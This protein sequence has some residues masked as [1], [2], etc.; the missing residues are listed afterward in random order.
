[1]KAVFSYILAALSMAIFSAAARADWQQDAAASQ[2]KIPDAY[3]HV[4]VD[5]HLNA[6][7]PMDL[8]FYDQKAQK[9]RF[10]DYFN[11]GRPV[12]LQ[13][14]YLECPM[15][16]DQVSRG[17]IES[18]KK[19]S[20][21]LGKDFDFIFVS[22]DPTDSPAAAAIKLDSYAAAYGRP[23]SASG[24]HF[25][26]GTESQIQQLAVAVGFR[27]QPANNGQFAHPAV[28]MIVSPEGKITRY[29]YG[30]NFPS[31]TLR[32]SLVDASHGKIGN[33]VDQILLICL[34][35]DPVTGKYSMMAQNMMKIGGVLTMVGLGGAIFWMVKRGSH[36]PADNLQPNNQEPGQSGGTDR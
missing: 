10:G 29:L 16:C 2:Q 19:I 27:Y 33:S 14:G 6:Q 26:V 36:H 21:T 32:L 18:S 35:F 13:L 3:A 9:V 5:E 15:L 25:L 23:G 11:S 1:M 7:L 28:A 17:L 12:I 8:W 31:E 20:L 30:I 22:I 24:F 34:C 4:G